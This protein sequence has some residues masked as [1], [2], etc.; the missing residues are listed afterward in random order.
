MFGGVVP[1]VC[2]PLTESFDVDSESFERLID[3]QIDAGVHGLFVLGSTSEMAFLTDRQRQQVLETA[4]TRARGRVPVVA[5]IIDMTTGPCLEHARVAARAG[6][7]GLVLTA[8]FY[9]RASQS[10]IIEHFRTI[11]SEVDLPIL[12]YDVPPAVHSKLE[13][14]TVVRLAQ[15]GL[16]VG[17]KDSSGDDANFRGLVLETR[18]LPNFSAFT[19]SELLVDSALLI[20]ASGTVPGL[21][22]VDPAGYV[23]LY[24]AA[25][26]G[27]WES[28]RREQERL[29]RLF[30]IV[31][32]GTIGRMGFG[33]SAMGG[34]KT[35]LVLRGVIATNVVGRPMTRFNDEE[36]ERVRVALVDAGVLE[37]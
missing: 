9:A 32:A 13:R 14:D 3:F 15:E 2:T 29:Y 35:A 7:D 20:G 17:I 27:D 5:G 24:N 26:C 37:S 33:S 10:E 23:R 6:V 1:P 8:P 12:A 19:G 18:S 25:C 30:S 21:G 31:Y 34:F 36:I 4:V 28:A 11:H 22:N 16:I